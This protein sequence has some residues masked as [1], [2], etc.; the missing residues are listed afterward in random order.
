MTVETGD[1]EAERLQRALAE[2]VAA[3]QAA[4]RDGAR[5]IRLL[6][7]IGTPAA[8]DDLVERTLLVLAEV[9]EGDVT[10]VVEMVGQRLQVTAACG[11]PEDDP[12]FTG[13]WRT[14]PTAL[15]ALRTGQPL[16]QPKAHEA[17]VPASLVPLGTCS[18]AWIPMSVGPQPRDDLLIIY[19][20]TGEAFS[21]AD[22]QVLAS[23]AHRMSD[24]V[25]ATER[26]A[27]IERLAEA[28]PSLARHGDGRSQ[29][30]DAVVLL[31]HVLGA[32]A[33]WAI[34]IRG[35]TAVLSAHSGL[36]DAQLQTWPRPT[37]TLQH[38]STLS[39]GQATVGS[40]NA[41]GAMNGDTLGSG[42]RDL[43]VPVMRDGRPV[44]LLGARGDRAR[45]FTKTAVEV[46]EILANYLAVAM[47]NADL[48]RALTARERD[49]HWQATHD[50]LTALANR[51][52]ASQRIE[53]A[54]SNSPTGMVGLLFCDLDKFK[55]VNDRLGHEAGDRLLQ[56]VA[57]RLRKTTRHGDLPARFGGD[58]FVYVAG[59]VQGVG[60]IRDL[61]R[62][63]QF[64]LV[65]PFLLGGERVSVSA[66]VGGVLGR[67]GEASLSAMLRDA[68]AAMYAAKGQGSGRIQ[69]LDDGAVRSSHGNRSG[70]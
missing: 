46:A 68:D 66:S 44:A 42:E 55:E 26:G 38:W 11:L 53:D 70:S 39:A 45:S 7:V 54:L 43:C 58:E 4:Y 1:S 15:E 13:G 25:E 52:A 67:N 8:P 62:R 49:L 28:G 41:A 22:L 6:S 10:C 33:A 40:W 51:A 19:R 2:A 21:T 69:I 9:F 31:R 5:L 35:P 30:R 20:Q 27:A 18:A 32:K 64:A 65:E 61:G 50:S 63:I 12:G 17:D 56:Q 16:T 14:G 24:V 60:D 47:D 59:A 36:T 57:Q 3:A 34:A 48:F 37:T 29:L 23:V